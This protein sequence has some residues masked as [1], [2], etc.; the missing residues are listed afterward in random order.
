MATDQQTA[1]ETF[2]R[3][4]STSKCIIRRVFESD[5]Q[6]AWNAGNDVG[7]GYDG[8]KITGVAEEVADSGEPWSHF[9]TPGKRPHFEV[10]LI[11]GRI[12][13]I[14]DS[15]DDWAVDITDAMAYATRV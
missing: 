13:A 10:C 4:T 8:A 15:H 1:A 6:T 9:W 3:I 5:I 12:V 14:G 2:A 7:D 11:D